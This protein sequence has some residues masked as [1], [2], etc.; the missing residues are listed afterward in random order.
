MIN[1]KILVTI[2]IPYYNGLK[3][4]RSILDELFSKNTKDFEILIID[5]Y[6][7]FSDSNGLRE[8]ISNNYSNGNLRYIFNEHNLGM[9]LNFEK[10]V[11]ESLGIYTWFFG[12]DDYVSKDNLTYCLSQIKIYNPDVIFANYSI[13][14]TWNYKTTYV[15]NDNLFNSSSIGAKDFIKINNGKVPSFLPSLIIKNDNWPELNIVKQFYGTHFIQLAIFIYNIGIN[16]KWLYIGKPLAIG[17]IP[18]TGW[19]NSLTNRIKYY[20]GFI[21]CLDTL[22]KFNLT[23]INQIVKQQKENSFLQHIMLSIESKLENEKIFLFSL[24]T[25][26]IFLPKHKFI[27]KILL[28][29]PNFLLLPIKF[30]RNIYYKLK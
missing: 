3:H 20:K 19:Q 10:C 15:F 6:S 26:I 21:E 14:R 30:I 25:D 23:G 1:N 17:V 12:Q 5:D 18:S 13:N 22:Q 11:K 28:Y 9:D 24:S 29:F 27:S 16:K 2:A 8:L 7:N 4:I